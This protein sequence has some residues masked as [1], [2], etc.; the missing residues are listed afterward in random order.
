MLNHNKLKNVSSK[1]PFY[2]INF[3]CGNTFVFQNKIKIYLQEIDDILKH[4]HNS[5][6]KYSNSR[7][8]LDIWNT[9]FYDIP[10]G[11]LKIEK[12]H[13][14]NLKDCKFIDNI[15]EIEADILSEFLIP[16]SFSKGVLHIYPPLEILMKSEKELFS[17][18]KNN[19]LGLTLLAQNTVFQ[20][21]GKMIKSPDSKKH[22]SRKDTPHVQKKQTIKSTIAHRESKTEKLVMKKFR[23]KSKTE[24]LVMKKFRSK[25]K[26]QRYKKNKKIKEHRKWMKKKFN[27]RNRICELVLIVLIKMGIIIYLPKLN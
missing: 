7:E 10:K 9:N 13:S 20:N 14:L 25:R 2:S 12:D 27:R 16:K 26:K 23:S 1:N 15:F 6:L 24:K 18:D 3:N 17:F 19:G 8:I 11:T 22:S 21:K 5:S 4:H